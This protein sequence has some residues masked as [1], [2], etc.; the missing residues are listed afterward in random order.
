MQ[1]LWIE[2]FDTQDKP[3]A[4]SLDGYRPSLFKNESDIDGHFDQTRLISI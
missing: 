1:I 3:V 2:Y 4:C